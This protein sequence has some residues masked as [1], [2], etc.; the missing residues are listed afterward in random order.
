MSKRE[1]NLRTTI[2]LIADKLLSAAE[3]GVGQATV[4][5]VRRGGVR[6]RLEAAPEEMARLR[7]GAGLG[8]MASNILQALAEA[9]GEVES[10]KL[11][12]LSGYVWNSYFRAAVRQ[13]QE[14]RVVVKGPNG[15]GLADAPLD[16]DGRDGAVE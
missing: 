8:E 10:K 4:V 15:Y 7:A 3:Q 6:I 12:R 2:L 9:G 1:S 14:A 16:Q 13:L 11:A 5:T